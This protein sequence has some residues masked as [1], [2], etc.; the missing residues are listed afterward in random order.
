MNTVETSPNSFASSTDPVYAR[1]AAWQRELY[2]RMVAHLP[3]VIS[4]QGRS[5]IDN[6]F[7]ILMYHRI[8]EA[9]PGYSFPTLNVTPQRFREQL[10]GLIQ[11]GY[12]PWPLRRVLQAQS[13]NTSIPRNAFV[14][15]FDDGYG[16]NYTQAWPIL[17]ELNVPATIFL[18]TAYLDTKV[19]FPFEVWSAAWDTR[20]P[21]DSW[22]PLS[23]EE[24]REMLD[25][26]L[27]DL[28]V[29]TH[30]HGD[31]SNQPEMLFD[32]LSKSIETAKLLFGLDDFTFAF[33]FGKRHRG[34]AGPQMA[35]AARRAKVLCS[36]TTESELVISGSDPFD[37]GRYTVCQGDSALT[38]SAK[39]NGWHDMMRTG[40]RSLKRRVCLR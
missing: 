5:R 4:R 15:T 13:D 8:S 11:R 14:V 18:T 17:K 2:Q 37:W 16:N 12:E 38:I 28:G 25:S 27:I 32:D 23:I 31:F 6:A 19:P 1:L 10:S 22:R 33:P 7:G 3:L 30:T 36:L 35:E 9:V 24:C 20:V 29:H 21:H 34:H 26:G 40:W 39:L